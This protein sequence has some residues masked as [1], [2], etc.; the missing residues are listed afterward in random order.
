MKLTLVTGLTGLVLL[1]TIVELLRRRQLREKYGMLW[2]GLLFVVIPLS[3]FPRLL[4]GVADLLGVASGVSLVLFLGIVF[5]LL[6]CIHLSW[7]V[8]ALEEETRTLA[9][10]VAL[11]RAEFEA[12]RAVREELV[13]RDG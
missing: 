5:L 9:E 4:D 6:V 12:D 1:A 7:E 11:I 10:E 8:S 13:S 2:L 3:L